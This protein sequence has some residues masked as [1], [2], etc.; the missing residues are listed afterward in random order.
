MK[1]QVMNRVMKMSAPRN[2]V[3][4]ILTLL[5]LTGAA[6]AQAG[7]NANTLAAK[8]DAEDRRAA[9]AYKEQQEM[10]EKYEETLQNQQA[11]AASNDPWGTVRPTTPSAKPA[12][13]PAKTAS[14][15]SKPATGSG[16]P[17]IGAAA[18]AATS[19]APKGQ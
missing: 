10:N 18:S 2:L 17:A 1:S 5:A 15:S 4:A 13:K 14:G 16:K 12:V 6:Y 9:K 3:L 8:Q 19:A 11:P 7:E